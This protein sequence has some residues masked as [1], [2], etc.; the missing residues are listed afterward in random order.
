MKV[1]SQTNNLSK[2]KWIFIGLVIVCTATFISGF[3]FG[4]WFWL[5][6]GTA[7][8]VYLAWWLMRLIRLYR[9]FQK[10]DQQLE[11][12]KM[13]GLLVTPVNRLVQERQKAKAVQDNNK[14]LI[15]QFRTMVEALPY[16]TILVNKALTIKYLNEHA[17]QMFDL[18][19]SD[20]GKS[21]QQVFEDSKI[22]RLFDHNYFTPEKA[23]KD[24]LKAVQP[25]APERLIKVRVIEANRHRTL[26]LA[27]DISAMEALQKSRKNFMANASHE[28]RTPLT[29]ITGYLEYLQNRS[30][31]MP[32]LKQAIEQAYEQSQRMSQII[33][34]MLTL[35]RIEHDTVMS[36]EED[37]IDMPQLLNRLFNDVKHGTDAR[38]HHFTAQID[39]DLWLKG[40][41]SE[42]TGVCLNLLHNA[43]LHT[44]PGTEVQLLW[45]RQDGQACLQVK[46]N[47]PGIAAKHI[48]HVTER[49][50]RVTHSV[51][52]KQDSTG[53]GLAIVKH[54]GL[55]HGAELSIDSQ[56]N[57]GSCFRM[58]FP[59]N[60]TQ[61]K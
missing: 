50:Y 3:W 49:F 29:V 14:E 24:G 27:H 61:L 36:E 46:D 2:E 6:A 34:D 1:T 48:P 41:Q 20:V 42:I 37:M 9:W 33:A 12:P 4:G 7:L 35:S 8:A 54:I 17:E 30:A 47:G 57:K 39:S 53:L 18:S 5:G 44:P 51:K 59:H 38:E 56:L 22:M 32:Q 11:P 28:L 60:R 19:P 43:V 31:E 58:L 10:N 55:K 25:T 45:F 52:Q 15:Q 13:F 26:L 21:L 16:A 40:N 23:A